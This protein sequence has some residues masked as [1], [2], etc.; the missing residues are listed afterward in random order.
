[1]DLR[2]VVVGLGFR[3]R[4]GFRELRLWCRVEAMGVK[5]LEEEI[6]DGDFGHQMTILPSSSTTKENEGSR[7]KIFLNVD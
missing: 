7:I 6:R 3:G 4:W 2:V 1:M 5:G